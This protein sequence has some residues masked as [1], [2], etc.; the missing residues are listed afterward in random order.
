MHIGDL[1]SGPKVCVL[2]H[3]RTNTKLALIIKELRDVIM[4]KYIEM[5]IVF[6]FIGNKKPML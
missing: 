2:D 3:E 4:H 6:S 5:L 1:Q